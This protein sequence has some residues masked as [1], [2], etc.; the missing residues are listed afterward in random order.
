[1]PDVYTP[2][3]GLLA[4]SFRGVP[5]HV[6][7]VSTPAGRRVHIV[8]FP[9]SDIPAYPDLGK[10]N[11]PY[12]INGVIAGDDWRAQA[13]ALKAAFDAPGAGTLVHPWLGPVRVVLTEPT[14]L[15]TRSDAVRLVTFEAAFAPAPV[16]SFS[17]ATLPGLLSAAAGLFGSASSLALAAFTLP[18]AG[19]AFTSVSAVMTTLIG[20]L[21]GGSEL[22]ARGLLPSLPAIVNG[23]SAAAWIISTMQA[24]GQAGAPRATPAIGA[25]P[26]GRSTA[27]VIA[28]ATA[29]RLLLDLSTGLAPKAGAPRADTS[30]RLAARSAALAAA[31]TPIN[32]IAYESR[33]DAALWRSTFGQAIDA[34]RTDATAAGALP[35]EHYAIWSALG[36]LKRSA[37]ADIDERIGRLPSVRSITPPSGVSAWLIAQ[38]VAGDNPSRVVGAFNDVVARNRLRHPAAAGPGAIEVLPS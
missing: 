15:D 5:F 25:G 35:Q 8:A 28:P 23:V 24:I 10:W 36:D 12:R 6:P 3:P 31:V 9:G 17:P 38:H 18:M 4:A 19:A 16:F 37:F 13:I 33:Q 27:P 21:S 26:A 29:A 11:G 30:L 32:A 20:G 22:A 1:M 34:A 7:D 2:M 14:Y